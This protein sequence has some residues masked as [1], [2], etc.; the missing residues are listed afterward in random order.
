M[1]FSQ[2]FIHLQGLFFDLT[3]CFLEH[4]CHTICL[5]DTPLA[6]QVG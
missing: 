2:Y 6:G 3:V 4:L 5:S 1:L